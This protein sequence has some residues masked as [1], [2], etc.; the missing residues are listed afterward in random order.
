MQVL[1]VLPPMVK[2]G[3]TKAVGADVVGSDVLDRQAT[4]VRRRRRVRH[5]ETLVDG[6]GGTRQFSSLMTPHIDGDRMV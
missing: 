6:H 3:V 4:T 1:V 5:L 2:G